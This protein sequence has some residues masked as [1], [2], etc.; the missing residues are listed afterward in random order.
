MMHLYVHNLCLGTRTYTHTLCRHTRSYIIMTSHLFVK[1][2]FLCA[3]FQHQ[4]FNKRKT[5]SPDRK[6]KQSFL[7]KTALKKW[8]RWNRRSKLK[9]TEIVTSVA[10]TTAAMVRT[11]RKFRWWRMQNENDQSV[12]LPAFAQSNAELQTDIRVISHYWSCP[13]EE[14]A[15]VCASWPSSH[16]PGARKCIYCPVTRPR[17][18]VSPLVSTVVQSNYTHA[19]LHDQS[20]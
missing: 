12:L 10:P 7:I 8:K 20:F 5:K 9:W 4:W 6:K 14:T 2:L 19:Y 1:Y 18:S 17:L 15:G 11:R 3:N 13:P 16:D